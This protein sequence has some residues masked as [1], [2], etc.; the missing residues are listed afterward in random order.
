MS[1]F[2]TIPLYPTPL[3]YVKGV[4]GWAYAQGTASN[5]CQRSD[6]LRPVGGWADVD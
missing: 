6:L 4:V 5:R 2:P 3:I 1:K